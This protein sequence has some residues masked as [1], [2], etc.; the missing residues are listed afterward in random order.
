MKKTP[1][2]IG[3]LICVALLVS[4]YLA[5]LILSFLKFPGSDRL[6]GVCLSATIG[7]PILLWIYI[8]LYGKVTNKKTITD[9]FPQD[10]SNQD[11]LKNDEIGSSPYEDECSDS[12]KSSDSD[13]TQD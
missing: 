13:T 5:T 11:L 6:F 12:S 2:Q 8:W 4:L 9:L 3:A 10:S 1:K 7:V